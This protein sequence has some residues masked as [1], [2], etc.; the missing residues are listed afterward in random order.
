MDYAFN[1]SGSYSN[2]AKYRPLG[3]ATLIPLGHSLNF[4]CPSNIFLI[5]ANPN[6]PDAAKKSN[7]ASLRIWKKYFK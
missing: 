1:N 7:E 5:S 2:F 3:S 6:C 4:S